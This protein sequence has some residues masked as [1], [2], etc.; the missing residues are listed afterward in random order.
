M[1][2][3]KL[4]EK[5]I[6]KFLPPEYHNCEAISGF[7][8]AVNDSY[9]AYERDNEL[10]T[11]AFRI[12][13]EEY[14]EIN[15]KLKNEI[16]LKKISIS[17]LKEAIVS[18]EDND[19]F[20]QKQND[21]LPEIIEY[22]KTQISKR[23]EA[24][25]ELILAREQAEVSS[26]AKETFLMNMSHEIRTPMN[27]ILGMSNE[28]A[29]TP[30]NNKQH[31][32]LDVINSASENLLVILND[33]LD[34][35]K[36]EAGKLYLENIGF[37]PQLVLRRSIQVFLHRAEEKGLSIK[38]AFI[39]PLLSPVLIGDPY[40]LNQ[41]LLNLI[42]NALKFTEKGSIELSCNVLEDTL[43][44]QI[45]EIEVKDTGI[46]MDAIFLKNVFQK[47][48]QEDISTAR[49]YGGTGLGMAICKQLAEMMSGSISVKSEKNVGTHIFLKIQLP[50][51]TKS[52]LPNKIETHID[53]KIFK[54]LHI[55]LV[56]DNEMNRL[57]AS[58]MLKSNGIRI[59][60]V[61]NGLEAVEKVLKFDYDLILMDIQMPI[62]DGW[63]A[64]KKIR[65][66]ASY[67]I[68]IIA[69]TANAFKGEEEKCKNSGMDGY[70]SKPFKDKELF[71]LMA[72][73]I[74]T[75]KNSDISLSEYYAT[76]P[77][78]LSKNTKFD[79]QFLYEVFG[80]KDTVAPLL[81]AFINE[82]KL[83]LSTLNTC[84]NDNHTEGLKDLVHRLKA[85]LTML[86]AHELR[87][88]ANK[89]ETTSDS[90]KLTFE[91][92]RDVLTFKEGLVFILN[93]L[94]KETLHAV[95]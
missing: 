41:I 14:E 85:N 37:E 48:L 77:P 1:K 64:T 57:V 54:N 29:K 59:T 12:S 42:S 52:D 89:I 88:L 67:H 74:K 94:Q 17:K 66:T 49:K 69:L 34:L 33:I 28:L 65:E 95:C 35:S 63:E 22:L 27:A 73:I 9:L 92:K 72:Q 44:H 23:K 75:G 79:L 39:D 13:E 15:K 84:L 93:E 19:I 16:E 46:G 25:E 20:L 4:L 55:L 61:K 62:M 32:Y 10:A 81:I 71:S 60:E 91:L 3:N 82:G 40:R 78:I 87:I 5:Q 50:K 6:T 47:F 26:K 21:D 43:S 36:I 86:N 80:N 24:E 11:R 38:S 83:A 68:P 70:L 18:L 51:G 56:D 7:I 30:L 53:P 58:T 2:K 90:D 31:F 8:N 76:Q 45:I